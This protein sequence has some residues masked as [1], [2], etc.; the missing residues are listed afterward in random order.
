MNRLIILAVFTAI[1]LLGA[2]F[3]SAVDVSAAFNA[4]PNKVKAWFYPAA[5]PVPLLPSGV[6]V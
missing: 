5:D 3:Y 6:R 1:L 2:P 4:N